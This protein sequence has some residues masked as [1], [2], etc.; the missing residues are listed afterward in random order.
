[1]IIFANNHGKSNAA[2]TAGF[3]LPLTLW[4][5]ALFGLGIAAINN[6]VSTAVENART[7]QQKSESDLMAANITNELVYAIATQPM[8]PRGLEVGLEINNPG[9]G[10]PMALM[11]SINESSDYIALDGRPYLLEGNIDYT[12]QIQDG[13]GLMNLQSV[14]SERLRR[15]LALFD[16]PE[17]LRNQLPDT[18]AD[19]MDADDLTR[20]TGAEKY[21]YERQRRFPPR[22]ENLLTPM[23]AQNILGWDGI[24]EVWAA[25]LRA[26][27]FT[28]CRIAGFNPN[29]APETILLSY[30]SGL[31]K[32][33][34][35]NVIEQRK[36]S[37]FRSG[38]EFMSATGSLLA[39][40]PF[41][42]S[43]VPGNCFIVDL[44]HRE[45]GRRVR[46][47]LSLVPSSQNKPWQVDYAF[48][49]PSQINEP[50]DGLSPRLAFPTPETLNPVIGG[51]NRVSGLR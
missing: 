2:K 10:D 46:Y 42:F 1:M 39:A 15:L 20:L 24:P 14:T 50:S 12:I 34:A 38:R 16:I 29:T 19:W 21:E 22:N 17:T 41:F 18:L 13:R 49:I 6:W 25:D 43:V 8:S 45:S 32:D 51:D 5:I 37:P 27:L 11:A 48:N 7:L 28:T 33:A 30:I 26:P 23:E 31:T 4:M 9:Q 35:S 47:S 44:T 40:E 3:V 36:V